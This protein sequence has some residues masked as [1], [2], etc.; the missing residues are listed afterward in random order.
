MDL[1]DLATSAA[2]GQPARHEELSGVCANADNAF[3]ERPTPA[4]SDLPTAETPPVTVA[5]AE[6]ARVA[7]NALYR[8]QKYPEVRPGVHI[9]T[10]L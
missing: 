5:V 1:A 2:A 9:S 4:D 10:V 8:E 6:A 7:G 3:S